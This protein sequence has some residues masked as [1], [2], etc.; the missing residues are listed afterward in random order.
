MYLQWE[1]CKQAPTASPCLRAIDLSHWLN[2]CEILFC[3]VLLKFV[4][5]FQYGLK[6]NKNDGHITWRPSC[7]SAFIS[8]I[9][10]WIFI[11]VKNVSNKIGKYISVI[12]KLNNVYF[13][14]DK[15]LYMNLNKKR[16]FQMSTWPGRTF[17][18]HKKGSRHISLKAGLLLN[19]QTDRDWRGVLRQQ[20]G[21]SA[22]LRQEAEYQ[23]LPQLSPRPPG[24]VADLPGEWGLGDVPTE[25][26]L[27]APAAAGLYTVYSIQ[28]LAQ[29]VVATV[30]QCALAAA[31]QEQ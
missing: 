25:A 12:R 26:R 24:G 11:R 20:V 4:D 30:S 7:I 29:D 5:T 19:L 22:G 8:S 27:H 31:L 28:L 1:T 2:F 18:W 14:L 6:L 16:T 23:L 17:A 15:Q 21:R 9:I 3:W 10:C 13:N